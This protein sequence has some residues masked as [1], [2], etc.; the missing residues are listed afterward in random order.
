MKIKIKETK[1]E[2]RSICVNTPY[3]SKASIVV[4]IKGGSVYE[5][6][7]NNGVFHLI[8][9]SILN[10]SKKYPTTK[11]IEKKLSELGI[12]QDVQTSREFTKYSFSFHTKNSRDALKF[13]S[14]I[15]INPIFDAQQIKQEKKIILEE[16]AIDKNSNYKTFNTKSNNVIFKKTPLLLDPIGT[17]TSLNN[18]DV[19]ILKEMHK[20]YYTANNM[21]VVYAGSDSFEEVFNTINRNF[22]TLKKG[23]KIEYPKLQLD[24]DRRGKKNIIKVANNFNFYSSVFSVIFSKRIDKDLFYL[25]KVILNKKIRDS[26]IFKEKISYDIE[27]EFTEFETVGLLDINSSFSKNNKEKIIKTLNKEISSIKINK[28]ELQQAKNKIL[29]NLDFMSD[30]PV[31]LSE[32]LAFNLMSDGRLRTSTQN[33]KIFQEITLLEINNF[34]KRIFIKNNNFLF[35]SN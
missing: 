27:I 24:K 23:E 16:M 15:I 35:L 3:L 31:E 5:D 1:N 2:F 17:K 18:I 13:V 11:K 29:D 8:E 25:L 20:K 34:A 21:V 26:L 22:K 9:H 30:N 14:E 10:G 28:T 12:I 6:N 32:Y 19:K 7:K 33:S 4:L